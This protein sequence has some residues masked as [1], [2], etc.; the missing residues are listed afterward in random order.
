MKKRSQNEFNCKKKNRKME[1]KNTKKE[2]GPWPN[3]S[4]LKSLDSAP[5][6]TWVSN[7]FCVGVARRG[8]V[9]LVGLRTIQMI[10]KKR[11]LALKKN[12]EDNFLILR[13]W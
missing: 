5:C 9:N 12:Q 7:H 4:T 2:K 6:L 8:L 1:L 10:S 3:I 13:Q 11:G